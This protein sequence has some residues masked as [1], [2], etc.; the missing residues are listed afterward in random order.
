MLD[1][2]GNSEIQDPYYRV[3][4]IRSIQG[5]QSA[6]REK[7]HLLQKLAMASDQHEIIQQ[8]GTSFLDSIN[9]VAFLLETLKEI[10]D[11]FS[12]ERLT[13]LFD[14]AAHT[15]I[16]TQQEIFFEIFKLLHGGRIAVKAAVYPTVTSYG[17]NFEIGQDA[18]VLSTEEG[19][20]LE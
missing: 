6:F 14:E 19:S 13:L 16:P 4:G 15:F 9:D 8:I 7:I 1:L 5:I 11:A 18:I 20:I 17:R 12:L 3:F 2:V 10:I